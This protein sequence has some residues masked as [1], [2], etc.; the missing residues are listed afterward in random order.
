MSKNSIILL[1]YHR[2]KL[3]ETVLFALL[4]NFFTLLPI[5]S[6]YAQRAADIIFHLT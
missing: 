3:L 5:M 6:R 1:L 2:Y 4:R